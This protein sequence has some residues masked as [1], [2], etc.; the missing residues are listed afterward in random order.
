MSQDIATFIQKLHLTQKPFIVGHSMGGKVLMALLLQNPEV[1]QKAAI[2]DIAPVNYSWQNDSMHQMLSDFMLH[3]P[4]SVYSQRD[5][6]H[7]Q[8]RKTFSSETLCQILFKNIRKGGSGFEWKV[9]IQT[10]AENIPT[11]LSWPTSSTPKHLP[12]LLFIR[13]DRSNYITHNEEET[14]RQLFPTAEIATLKNASH[15]LH[16]DQP[17]W[18]IAML[19]HFFDTSLE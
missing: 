7:T 2:L 5:E 6:I 14:I 8:I 3:F 9:N 10:I 11:L 4:L 15:F 16:I 19:K 12:P 18:L 17:T 1:S 13:G